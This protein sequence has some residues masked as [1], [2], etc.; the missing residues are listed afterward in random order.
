[1]FN[2]AHMVID[3]L[4]HLPTGIEQPLVALAAANVAIFGSLGATEIYNRTQNE[5]AVEVPNPGLRDITVIGSV[6]KRPSLPTRMKR[7]G[8]AL[9]TFVGLT[10]GLGSLTAQPTYE[11]HA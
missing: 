10:V 1:M 6:D 4:T 2:E 11:S 5:H 7:V 3:Q 8:A 9:T